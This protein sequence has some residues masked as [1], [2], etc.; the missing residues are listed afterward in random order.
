MIIGYTT[1]V[2]DLFHVGHLNV[3]RKA[4][5][6]C[7]YLVV[8]VTSD[9]LVAYKNTKSVIPFQERIKIVEAIKYVDEV[10][11]QTTMDKMEAWQTVK[12]NKM[13]VGSDWQGTDK[14]NKIEKDFNDIGVEVIYFPYTDG[15]SS[16]KLKE[17]LN[18]ITNDA[19]V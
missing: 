11:A 12:F 16:T 15:T 7:D 17:V 18:K 8:G 9:E 13:F 6:N 2:F 5:E 19:R 14:W 1:G 3:L 4:K 10:V